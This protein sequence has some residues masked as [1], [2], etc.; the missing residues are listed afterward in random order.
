[1]KL[2]LSVLAAGTA[3][4]AFHPPTAPAQSLVT[5]TFGE[6]ADA[7]AGLATGQTVSL[8]YARVG[9]GRGFS[10]AAGVPTD[11]D[12]G[13]RW[14]SATGWLESAR[15]AGPIGLSGLVTGFTYR[16]PVLD[17]TGAGASATLHAIS[18]VAAPAGRVRFRAGGRF[19]GF[20]VGE[21]S[22]R[23]ALPGAGTE[24]MTSPGPL[25]LVGSLDVW[26]VDDDLYPE[27]NGAIRVSWSRFQVTGSASHWLH[28]DLP[29][30]GWMVGAEVEVSDR[31][32][33]VAHSSVAAVDPLF[34][35]PSQKY[36]RVGIRALTGRRPAPNLLVPAVV[37]ASRPVRFEVDASR[38]GETASVAGSFSDWSPL[39][40]QREGDRWVLELTLDPGIHEFAFIDAD[41]EWFVPDDAPGRKADGYG[42]FVATLVVR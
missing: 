2:S 11:M 41:G 33:A 26:S 15:A 14:A 34:W 30:T 24:V 25:R 27:L 22:L 4:A 19:G 8:A 5:A 10:I 20:T 29:D 37:P 1:M 6:N 40:M 7:T 31:V 35:T 38:A 16:D 28:E 17:A 3:F 12:D 32:T 39:P 9:T 13:T 42:G 18:D 36:W 21:S 23:R